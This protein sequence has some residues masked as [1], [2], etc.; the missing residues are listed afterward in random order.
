MHV[1]AIW[2]AAV[3]EG[4]HMVGWIICA[5]YLQRGSVRWPRTEMKDSKAC[6]EMKGCCTKMQGC[7]ASWY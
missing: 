1:C 7:M 4:H 5:M 6:G 2:S 3:E